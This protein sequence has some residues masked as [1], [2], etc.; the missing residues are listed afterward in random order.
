MGNSKEK[1]YIY[2]QNLN[3]ITVMKKSLFILFLSCIELLNGATLNEMEK[4][5][6]LIQQ[7]YEVQ[8]SNPKQSAYYATQAIN[9]IKGEEKNDIK[10]EAMLA[11]GSAQKLLGE[12]DHGIKTLYEGLD[13]VT[14]SNKS[15]EGEIYNMIS[16]LYCRLSDYR[17]SIS[18]NEKATAIFKAIGDSAQIAACYNTKGIVHTYLNEF[19]IAEQFFQQALSINRSLKNIKKIAANLNNLCLY[20]GNTLEK[21]EFIKEAIA[22]N[23]NLNSTWSLAE[24]YNNMGKQ[25]YYAKDYPKA[26]EALQKAQEIAISLGAKDLMCDNYEYFSWCYAKLGKYQKA[27]NYLQQLTTL[28]KELHSISLLRNTEQ[29]IAQKKYQAQRRAAE[30]KEQSYKIELLKRNQYILVTIF[31]SLVIVCIFLY[32]WYKRKKNMELVK[33]RYELEQSEREIAELKVRQQELELQSVQDALNNSRQEATS[34][35]VFLQSR[36]E[37]LEKIRSMIKEGYKLNNADINAHLKKVNAFIKQHQNGDKTNSALLLTIEEKNQEFLKRLMDVHP[38]LTQGE[39]YL[40]TLLRV[41]L[42]TKEIAMLT[43]TM[44]KTINMNRYRLRKSL[45]ISSEEDLT[46]YLQQI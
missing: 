2:Q 14:P 31:I 41:N 10:A 32:K 16:V 24:N 37:L 42:S 22:I 6:D 33:A 20:E 28:S 5:K 43:G 23:K 27:Y 40:A 38:N 3:H 45:G 44:P 13:Y 4:A 9:L 8:Y 12:F 15:L 26:L 19:T 17:Q 1:N 29:E 11:L 39:K 35:A 36:N 34:F 21:L 30:L 25:Y 46:N 7:A 18:L